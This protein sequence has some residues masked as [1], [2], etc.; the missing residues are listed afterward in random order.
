MTDVRTV[1]IAHPLAGVLD[2]ERRA[3]ARVACDGIDN[4]FSTKKG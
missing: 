3:M 1:L 2:D 4:W